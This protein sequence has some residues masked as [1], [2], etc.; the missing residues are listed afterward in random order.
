MSM[1]SCSQVPE[2]LH[3]VDEH[4]IQHHPPH[5]LSHTPQH[6][7][8]KVPIIIIT[9]LHFSHARTP[10]FQRTQKKRVDCNLNRTF[11]ISIPSQHDNVKNGEKKLS[12]GWGHVEEEEEKQS[13]PTIFIISHCLPLHPRPP[14]TQ[15]DR[16]APWEPGS[17]PTSPKPQHKCQRI[18]GQ[19]KCL[20][21]R[22]DHWKQ[23][24]LFP[25]LMWFCS[26]NL[27][28]TRGDSLSNQHLHC[29]HH[30]KLPHDKDHSKCLGDCPK[31]IKFLNLALS[32][33]E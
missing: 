18:N 14:Q 15:D 2:H 13:H 20:A 9:I 1:S 11:P 29:L 22:G 12:L 24:K 27:E 19:G 33:L 26:E 30:R 31:V 16:A 6:F 32:V 17:D 7:Y 3:A 21:K 10:R 28:K 8:N 4:H 23:I 25:I 5:C